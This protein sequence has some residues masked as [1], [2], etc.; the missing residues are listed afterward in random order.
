MG[1]LEDFI[2]YICEFVLKLGV[3]F[4]VVLVGNMLMMLGLLKV[5]V[6]VKMMIDVE[7]K[8]MGLF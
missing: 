1:V 6:V 5:L 3:G 4:I 2:F 8:I 7:G